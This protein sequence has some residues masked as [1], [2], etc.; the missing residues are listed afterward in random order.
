MTFYGVLWAAASADTIALHF[1]LTI[2][3]VLNGFQALVIL[4]PV[5]GFV[6]TRSLCV[7]LQHNEREVVHHGIET[8]VIIRSPDGG[9]TEVHRHVDADDRRRRQAGLQDH[10]TPTPHRDIHGQVTLLQRL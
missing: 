2:E 6:V 3:T 10:P 4:G 9:Y 1:H 8:G 5:I 7:A